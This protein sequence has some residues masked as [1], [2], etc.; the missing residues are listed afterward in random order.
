MRQLPGYALWLGHVGDARD[1]SRVHFAGIEALVDLAAN[2]PPLTVSRSLV[3]CRFPVVD[4]AGNPVW[5]L[6]SAIE[7]VA[8]LLA[9][10]VPTLIVCSAGMSRTPAIAA[11][12]IVVHSKCSLNE[13]LLVVARGSSCDIS[14]SLLDDVQQILNSVVRG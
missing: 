10:G 7:T 5:L 9:E 8:G 2:E 13:A 14:P 12:A 4:G 11:A 3:Y 1:M 6:R